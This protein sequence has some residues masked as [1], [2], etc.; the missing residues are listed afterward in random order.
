MSLYNMVH[1]ENPNADKLLAMLGMAREEFGRFRDAYL[2]G[3][4]TEIIVYTRI[5]GDNRD[6]YDKVFEDMENS[7]YYIQDYDDEYDETYCYFRFD[8]P[9]KYLKETKGAAT[10][11]EPLTVHE[12]FQQAIEEMKNPNSNAAQVAD[13][14]V[15][16]I[17][18]EIAKN[19]KG[20]VI[21]LT[22]EDL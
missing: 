14:I 19:P 17:G 9:K 22:D 7:D 10:G 6:Y 13:K 8:V 3:D 2:N 11:E 12:K 16:K 5:G 18:N 1:G 4:G 15:N 20:G 21:I